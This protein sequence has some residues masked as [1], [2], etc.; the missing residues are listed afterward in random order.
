MAQT[1]CTRTSQHFERV[2]NAFK[3]NIVNLVLGQQDT[4]DHCPGPTG[5]PRYRVHLGSTRIWCLPAKTPIFQHI[6]ESRVERSAR[7]CKKGSDAVGRAEGA[8]S[9]QC[10]SVTIFVRDQADMNAEQLSKKERT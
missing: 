7:M 10:A 4:V 8:L 3:E 9:S 6:A 5:M 2:H 1:A